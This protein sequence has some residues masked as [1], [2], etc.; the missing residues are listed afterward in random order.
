MYSI[1]STYPRFEQIKAEVISLQK[2]LQLNQI[3]VQTNGSADWEQ[4]AGWLKNGT[5]EVSFNQI[6]PELAGS[7]IDAYLKWL[8][9]QVV[10]TRVMVMAP[11]RQYSVHKDPTWRLHLPLVTNEKAKFIFAD[12]NF[13]VHMPADGRLHLVDTRLMHTAVNDGDTDR[14]HLVSVVVDGSN[15]SQF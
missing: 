14:I 5:T 4:S 7:E 11:G 12:E 1:L 9:F 3:S 13:S 2:R 8:P 15:L 6:H 10:R